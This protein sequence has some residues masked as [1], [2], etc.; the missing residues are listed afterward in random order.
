MLSV[1]R[2]LALAVQDERSSILPVPQVVRHKRDQLPLA[3]IVVTLLRE[4]NPAPYDA[5]EL[6]PVNETVCLAVGYWRHRY[7][8]KTALPDVVHVNAGGGIWF[9]P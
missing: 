3:Q 1:Y 6:Y 8:V 4:K 9:L 7:L 2:P 5:T